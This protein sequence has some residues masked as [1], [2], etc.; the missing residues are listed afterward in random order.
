[1]P[2]DTNNDRWEEAM[3][4]KATL[5]NIHDLS[6][7]ELEAVYRD[8]RHKSAQI[9]EAYNLI[10]SAMGDDSPLAQRIWDV[11]VKFDEAL[12][13]FV[14]KFNQL[15]MQDQMQYISEDQWRSITD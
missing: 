11:Y 13:P 9:K 14:V 6:R 2:Q 4:L 12:H 10:R 1:M 5:P 3:R 8:G 7:E 15:M